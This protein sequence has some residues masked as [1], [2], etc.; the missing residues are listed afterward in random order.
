MKESVGR[1][2]S[3]WEHRLG[4]I[5]EQRLYRRGRMY[6]NP[7]LDQGQQTCKD[8]DSSY[9]RASHSCDFSAAFVQLLDSAM[10]YSGKQS[11]N[12]CG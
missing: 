1:A 4:G 3:T 8:S 10:P 2:D 9:S 11:T 7:Y 5:R 12:G 6:L